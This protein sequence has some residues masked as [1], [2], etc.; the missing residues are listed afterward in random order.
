[1]TL[2]P[3]WNFQPQLSG[4]SLTTEYSAP[5]GIATQGNIPWTFSLFRI[6]HAK[7]KNAAK[8]PK[9]TA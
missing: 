6:A 5:Q 2:L 9:P 3:I 1:M 7:R 4:P 8:Q